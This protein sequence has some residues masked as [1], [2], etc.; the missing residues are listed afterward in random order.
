[1][2][3]GIKKDGTRIRL[4]VSNVTFCDTILEVGIDTTKIC[5]LASDCAWFDEAVVGEA[6]IVRTTMSDS[7]P[8]CS[9]HAFKADLGLDSFL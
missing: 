7:Y 6:S 4:H 1:M 3:D 5:S 2:S 8:M 9:Y